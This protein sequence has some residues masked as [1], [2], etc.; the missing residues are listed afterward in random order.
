MKHNLFNKASKISVVVFAVLTALA[1][2][3]L[4]AQ[5]VSWYSKDFGITSP[6]HKKYMKQIIWSKAEIPYNDV[7]NSILQKRFDLK[8]PIYGR[9]FLEHSIR[10]TP[11]FSS[12]SKKPLENWKNNFVVKLFIDGKDTKGRF[13]VFYEA[14]YND[15]MGKQWTTW[16]FSPHLL[17]PESADEKIIAKAW[18]KALR[19][20]SAGEHEIRFEYWG[21]MGQQRTAEPLAKG[22]FTLVVKKGERMAVGN[23]F[24]KDSYSGSDV[25]KIRSA[26]KKAIVGP[27]AKNQN[28]VQKVA[29]TSN[30]KKGVYSDS[31]R[32]Y[33]TINGTV[34]WS[35]K[36]N[37][38]IY[39]F[40]SYVFIS[41]Q[42]GSGWTPLRYKGFCN[43]CPEGDTE[44]P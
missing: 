6:E 2:Q 8:D 28:E 16:Q 32:R 23:N 15:D 13:G 40:T 30:W 33:R 7:A 31:K 5:Q 4:N 42:N 36:D 41:D 3:A 26:M 10:N 43:G 18:E 1:A 35:D 25:N 44:Q 19:G 37:D 17:N 27:V 20:I 29:V 21:V 11:I 38:G 39:R 14:Y 9:V 22:S 24:P 34:L 12:G